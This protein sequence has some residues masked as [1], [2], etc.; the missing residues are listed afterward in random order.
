MCG[1]FSVIAKTSNYSSEKLVKVFENVGTLSQVRGKDSSGV[2][3]R[4]YQNKTINILKGAV[5]I[6]DLLK[7]NEYK[8]LKR[9][10]FNYFDNTQ[11]FCGFGHS[12]LVT[13]GSQLED[14]N[15]QPVIKNSIVG[16][17]NGIVVN[18]DKLWEE[19]S[20]LI[21]E[22]DIDTEVI[23]ALYQKYAHNGTI[24]SALNRVKKEIKGTVS[25]CFYDADYDIFCSFTNNGS[26]YTLTDYESLVVFSSEKYILE[27]L[28]LSYKEMFRDKFKIEQV[29]PNEGVIISFEDFHYNKFII[30]EPKELCFNKKT[31]KYKI[32]SVC[33]KP[34]FKQRSVI[35]DSKKFKNERHLRDLLEFN[36]DR[37]SNLKR[38]K[39]CLL[40]ETFPFIVFDSSGTCNYCNNYIPKNQE[41]PASLLNEIIEPYR[42]NNEPDC[43]IPFS[44]GRDSSY[45]VHYVKNELGL[46]PITFT[47]DWGMVTDLAR[48]N[49]ARICGKLGIENII[50]SAN[51]H[52]KREYI[53]KNIL[54]WLKYPQ[55]GMIPL[56]MAGDKYF[57]YYANQIR[58]QTGLKLQLWGIN[59]LENTDFKVGFAGIKPNFDKKLIYSLKIREQLKL[60]G[61]VGKNILYSPSYINNSL[62]DTFGS[63]ISRYLNPQQDYYHFF[64]YVKWDERTI[65]NTLLNEY[66]W[67]I[68]DDIKSTWRIGDGTASFYN[69][70]Y[71]TV[72]GF[73]E[74]DTFRSNQI[75]E[76]MI[77][78]ETALNLVS[79][80][81]Q[82]RYESLRWYLEIV[83]LNFEDVIKTINQIPK[84]Y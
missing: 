31:E 45:I 77:D 48:R 58:K 19:N 72:A 83:G 67:E 2:S 20:D 43:I 61:F 60:F 56:F 12:R 68:A 75:R 14:N 44:G 84:L 18:V 26:L 34:S 65:E 8:K 17:H 29:R 62:F 21:R 52:K 66:D 63:F 11:I 39:K 51:I 46:N 3:F 73:S 76:G 38:C 32:L 35:V 50:V 53:Q 28:F 71:Y 13:N 42:K 24:I 74:F 69:Y 9:S 82:P 4:N 49:I 59:A 10:I 57:F 40:P 70:I 25:T 54:A 79:I 1:I 23:F 27:K 81:N 5:S 64:D 33:C 15:N 78:R 41:K 16:I 80:E 22:Y 30:N 6:D 47:Y 37:I 7:T 36:I 55:L